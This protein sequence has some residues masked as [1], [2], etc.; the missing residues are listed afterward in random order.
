MRILF[1]TQIL[2]FPPDS[3]P[4]VK[5][6]NVLRYLVDKGHEVTLISFV[7][8][9]EERFIPDVKKLHLDFYKVPIQRNRFRDIVF[10][11]KSNLSG[12]PF[13]VERDNLPVMRKIVGKLLLENDYD[14]FHAD[15]LTMTQFA[16]LGQFTN[17]RGQ[18]LI[19][20]FDAHNA[21]YSILE[22]MRENSAWFLK[23]ALQIE[24]RRV[25]QY[26]HKIV[27]DFDYTLAVTEQDRQLLMNSKPG[28]N[29]KERLNDRI[30]VIPIAVDTQAQQPVESNLTSANILTLGTLRY[31]PNADGIRWFIKEVFPIIR[32]QNP[33]A[34]LT[35]IGMNP[36][37]DFIEIARKSNGSIQVTGY[38]EKLDPFLQ[39]AALMVVP[40]RAGSGMRV[41]ILEAF[42]R[43]IPVVT[44]SIGIE[45]IDARFEE[46]VLIADRP[47]EFAVQ[48]GR[49]LNDKDLRLRLARNGRKLVVSLYDWQVVLKKIDE[50][51]H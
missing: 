12:R 9:T 26:E 5:T 23:P 30:F 47:D 8:K 42:A 44:T 40:V 10:W 48:V 37:S 7:R 33:S 45:G 39:K 1:L 43:G 3:G 14:I 19:R 6:W 41:R 27:E 29:G 24:A 4:K 46:D 16:P 13:L 36:P 34:D 22:R 31:P 28:E 11:F 20:V 49:L 50:I 38:I 17:H 2:P 35:V 25:R 21:T 51:Y 18:K 32:E 15:Q